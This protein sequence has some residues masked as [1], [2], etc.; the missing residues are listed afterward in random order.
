MKV[1][2]YSLMALLIIGCNPNHNSETITKVDFAVSG[3]MFSQGE[4]ISID[5]AL[6]Y[7][8]LGLL[9]KKEQ[10]CYQGKIS[11][12]TWDSLTQKL[13]QINF[14]T[15]SENGNKHILDVEYAELIIHW[16][17]KEKRIVRAWDGKSPLLGV[18]NWIATTTKYAN[19]TEVKGPIN[20]E[21]T[22]QNSPS[23]R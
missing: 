15:I 18:F 13:K 22:F 8:Y 2:L 19:L 9:G 4:A 23:E 17:N 16:N 1:Q 14:D 5:S 3:A 7:K 10:G 6:N 20:F 11:R 12:Q 21:T